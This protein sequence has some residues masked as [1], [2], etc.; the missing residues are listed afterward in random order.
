[1]KRNKDLTSNNSDETVD[2]NI[3]EANPA[4]KIQIEQI[5][6]TGAV[7]VTNGKYTIYCL[8]IVGE[9][10]GHNYAEDF[11]KTTK[12]EK[13]IP[14][15]VAIEES[16]SIDGLLILLNTVGGDIEA[17]L[18]LAELV[19][20]MRKPTVSMVIGGGHSI[21]VPLAVAAKKTF[22]AKTAS[23]MVHPVRT[24]GTVLGTSQAFEYLKR[25]QKRITRFV[26]DNSEIS[27]ERY[28]VSSDPV[29]AESSLAPFSSDAARSASTDFSDIGLSAAVSSRKISSRDTFLDFIS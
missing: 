14:Q 4:S 6:E 7:V 28:A 9:I 29:E 16:P 3:S 25:M 10:E 22:I 12:Y 17:G 23:M 18:S 20:G 5:N 15:L 21:G 26:E 1:M 24:T 8:T 19:S 2:K 13:V 27:A 11:V